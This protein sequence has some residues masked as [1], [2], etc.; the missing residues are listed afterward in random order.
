L[1]SRRERPELFVGSSYTPLRGNQHVA[2][3]ARAAD[4]QT[5]LVAAPVQIA[6][7][8]RGALVPPIGPEIWRD[9]TLRV[10]GEPGRLYRDLF[11]GRALATQVAEGKAVLRL[12][13]VFGFFPVAVL[14]SSA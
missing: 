7:L 12:A 10:P 6:T 8:T 3:F 9:D 2:A 14:L 13:D 4:G 1:C 11:T 5:L